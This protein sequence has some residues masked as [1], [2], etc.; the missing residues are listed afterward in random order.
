MGQYCVYNI[1]TLKNITLHIPFATK[2]FILDVDKVSQICPCF[3]Y[4][5]NKKAKKTF[6]ENKPHAKLLK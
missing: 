1:I 5:L 6:N 3:I 2:S 4:D